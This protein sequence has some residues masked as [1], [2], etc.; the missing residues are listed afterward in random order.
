[1]P[2]GQIT[3]AQTDFHK[4]TY[5]AGV[6][7]RI[8]PTSSFTSPSPPV[9]V[10]AGSTPACRRISAAQFATFAPETV[11]A[12]EIGAKTQWLDHR[13]QLNVSAF[14][15]EYR[16]LQ[17]VGFDPTTLATYTVNGG[18]AVGRGVEVR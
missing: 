6:D 13:L 18:N 4:V 5:K 1:M 12:Y 15:N 9:F 14:D 10:P 17:I 11:T 7:Y 2:V 16:S 8:P 3:P